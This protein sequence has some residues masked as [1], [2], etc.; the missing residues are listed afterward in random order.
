MIY[1]G[2]RRGVSTNPLASGVP[3]GDPDRSIVLDM[4]TA[5]VALGKMMA[6]TDAGKS[7][8]ADWAVDADGIATTDPVKV[9]GCCPWPARR[10][11]ACR[12]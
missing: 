8:P 9:K 1:H 5:A 10:G 6:A 2:S 4:S 11:R 7:I 12:S 3:T